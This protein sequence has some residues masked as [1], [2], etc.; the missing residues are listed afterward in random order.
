MKKFTKILAVALLAIMCL[1]VLTACSNISE[2][3]A[4]KINVAAAKDEHLDYLDVLNDLGENAIDI[5]IAKTGVII[6]AQ[7]C[8]SLEELNAKLEAGETVKGI[9]VTL[10][11]GK[12]LSAEYKVLSSEDTAK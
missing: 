11:A 7:G 5:T 9:V 10:F 2:S 4:E 8:T 3:Y 6:A 1:T 12:A